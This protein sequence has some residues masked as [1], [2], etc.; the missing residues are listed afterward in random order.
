KGQRSFDFR[1]DVGSMRQRLPAVEPGAVVFDAE[2]D[3]HVGAGIR[4]TGGGRASGFL[5]L[6]AA[7]LLPCLCSQATPSNNRLA[8][9]F[10]VCEPSLITS[11]SIARAPSGSPMSR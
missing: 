1:L 11:S 3:A 5:L 2:G 4:G 6:H 10:C 8:S 9:S 7:C